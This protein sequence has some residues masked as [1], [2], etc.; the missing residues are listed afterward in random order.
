MNKPRMELR[1]AGAPP[2]CGCYDLQPRE[3]GQ[4]SF[5]YLRRLTGMVKRSR[6]GLKTSPYS[7][8]RRDQ[9]DAEQARE[10]AL[11]RA[12]LARQHAR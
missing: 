9:T 2:E 11:A 10:R 5:G 8:M 1:R 6:A 4:S 12:Q 3:A 7:E